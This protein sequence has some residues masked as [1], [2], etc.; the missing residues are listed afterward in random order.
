MQFKPQ[1]MTG[2]KIPIEQW[3]HNCQRL[4]KRSAMKT[5][6]FSTAAELRRPI[7]AQPLAASEKTMEVFEV[8]GSGAG[9]M[10]RVCVRRGAA[11]LEAHTQ[12]QLQRCNQARTP[13]S[14]Q[15]YAVCFSFVVAEL[16]QKLSFHSRRGEEK[17][18]PP[19][20][21]PIQV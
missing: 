14:Q 3:L 4:T 7:P 18:Q 12:N 9:N 16:F 19:S 8:I 11:G 15:P 6:T 20:L 10:G 1:T 5:C 13:P 21:Q 17:I 2:K